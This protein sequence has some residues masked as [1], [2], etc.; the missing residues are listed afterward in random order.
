[1]EELWIWRYFVLSERI[2]THVLRFM[3]KKYLTLEKSEN[4]HLPPPKPDRSYLLYVHIPFCETLC[5]YC[6]FNRFIMKE[7][8]AHQYFN[9]L[10]QE[11]RMVAE[12]GYKFDSIYIGGGT[13][14]LLIDEL[15]ET[16]DLGRSL[17]GVHDVSCET[18]PNH[19]NAEHAGKLVGR[20]Q[21]LSVGVQSFDDSLLKKIGRLSKYGSGKEI[22]ERIKDFAGQI[23]T[24]NVDMIFNFPGQTAK[25]IKYDVEQIIASGA[26][27]VSFYPLMT[28]PFVEKA[29]TQSLGKIS[30]QSESQYYQIISD[31]LA[32]SY[33]PSSAWTFSRK[34]E[35]LIDEYISEYDEYVGI[36]SGAFGYQEGALAVNTFSLRE[37]EQ[38]IASGNLPL[39]AVH[40][41]NPR[42]Q[43]RYRFMMELFGLSLDKKRF[44]R[45]F[46]MRVERGLWKEMIFMQLFGAFARN[47]R[48]K[49]LLTP[50][51]RYLLVV[52]M[53]EFFSSMDAVREQARQA[54]SSEEKAVLF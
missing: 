6:S 33:R 16:I 28:A 2:L 26:E 11:M 7:G 22:F 37:Y 53:R 21:R 38:K 29:L 32:G 23:P 1:M 50:K 41:F 5:P 51:G 36:G 18:N 8:I 10:R 19:L 13:P 4:N 24:L 27:Q 25:A 45:D 30:H 44:A 17:F 42:E 46:G 31:G 15:I 49:L 14:T 43:M 54:L 40:F 39:T 3:T 20:V 34:K 12:M 52:M 48:E 47:D 35:N 9:S